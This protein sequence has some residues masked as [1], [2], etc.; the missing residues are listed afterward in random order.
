M[1]FKSKD[2]NDFVEQLIFTNES[3]WTALCSCEELIRTDIFK[4]IIN[5]DSEET[6]Q[7]K[8]IIAEKFYK[9]ASEKSDISFAKPEMSADL[10]EFQSFGDELEKYLK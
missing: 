3:I 8:K 6:E 1:K 4:E 7:L 10:Q 5:S 9:K 2:I